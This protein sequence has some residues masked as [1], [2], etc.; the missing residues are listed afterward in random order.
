MS[1]REKTLA[2]AVAAMVVGVV[3]YLLVVTPVLNAFDRVGEETAA[4]ETKLN[5]ARVLVDNQA[6]IEKRWAGYRRAGLRSDEYSARRRTQES[7]TQWSAASRLNIKHLEAANN[8]VRDDDERFDEITFRMSATGSIHSLQRFLERVSMS[9]FPLRIVDC[10]I[11][12]RREDE[13]DL[14]LSLTLT[15]II[16]TGDAEDAQ[17]GGAS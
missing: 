12:N 8:P 7:I 2:I 15:T 6:L 11:T 4:L 1:K 14:D 5:E 10:S 9:P 13:E 17:P 16:Q 3:L